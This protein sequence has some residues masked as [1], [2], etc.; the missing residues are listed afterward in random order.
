MAELSFPLPRAGFSRSAWVIEPPA[1][2]A[3]LDK[4]RRA[5]VPLREYAGVSPLYGIKTGDNEVFAIRTETRDAL[6]SVDV[7]P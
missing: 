3:L 1:V 6:G 5:G 4:I 2:G 7:L